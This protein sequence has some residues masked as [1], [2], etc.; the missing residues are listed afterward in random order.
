MTLIK[1]LENHLGEISGGWKDRNLEYPIQVVSFENHPFED[2]NTYV[3]L[4]L[5]DHILPMVD[6][7]VIRQELVCTA[8]RN[9]AGEKVA[10]FLATFAESI[11][12][13]HKALLR[14]EVVGPSGPVILG[15]PL[16]SIFSAIPMIFEDSFG[17]FEQTT[18][19]TIF[20]WIIPIHEEEANYVRGNG[21]SKFEDLLE[22]QNPELWDLSRASIL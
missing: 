17:V 20:S 8:Y 12:S 4:G 5:S 18:P 16:N 19:Q 10:S 13:S 3:T 21:W 6:G 15:S 22:R 1:H 9:F 11:V 14:G 7:K 2:I